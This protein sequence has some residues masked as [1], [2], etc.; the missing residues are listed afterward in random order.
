MKQPKKYS[1][2]F[3]TVDD[4]ERK[5]LTRTCKIYKIS[6]STFLHMIVFGNCHMP[7]PQLED[8]ANQNDR[9]KKPSKEATPEQYKEAANTKGFSK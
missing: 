8:E 1:R 2:V 6:T 7:R 5:A 4:A 3:M 9:R